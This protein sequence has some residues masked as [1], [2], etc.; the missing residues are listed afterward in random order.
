[1]LS[2]LQVVFVCVFFSP[3][4]QRMRTPMHSVV[5]LLVMRMVFPHGQAAGPQVK[6][7]SH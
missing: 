1:M 4:L 2:E 5:T 6:N 7:Q 3:L